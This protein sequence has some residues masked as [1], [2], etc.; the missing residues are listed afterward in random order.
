MDVYVVLI[1]A[2]ISTLERGKVYEVPRSRV[3]RLTRDQQTS[4][5]ACAKR[6]GIRYT[7]NENK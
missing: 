6:R 4:I 3:E 7:I 5:R 2:K 1:C